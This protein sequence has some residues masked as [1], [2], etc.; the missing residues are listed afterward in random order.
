[1]LDFFRTHRGPILVLGLLLLPV[2][3][4]YGAARDD[5]S[6]DSLPRG[7]H[8]LT[9][10]VQESVSWSWHALSQGYGHYLWLVGIA[11]ENEELHQEV[12]QLKREI[13]YLQEDKLENQ[14]LMRLLNLVDYFPGA[15]FVP[16]RVIAAG[17]SAGYRS[18]RI[19][20]GTAHGVHRRA[21]VL[22]ANGVAGRVVVASTY[23][24]DVLLITDASSR[25]DVMTRRGRSRGVLRGGGKNCRIDAM[26]RTLDIDPGDLV[27]T[28]GLDGVFPKG[29]PVGEVSEVKL[30]ET[31]LYL[32]AWVKP[33][34]CEEN[35]EEL[36][37]LILPPAQAS[38][39]QIGKIAPSEPSPGKG[40][41]VSVVH[42]PPA[43]LPKTASTATPSLANKPSPANAEGRP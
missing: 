14:R 5:E 38:V 30:P 29:L 37:V 3:L 20:R 23:Y 12:S 2:I 6:S 10:P 19:N 36:L 31:G 40:A 27:V 15:R 35:I 4:L 33:F 9:G 17:Q 7:L 18:L 22:T 16:A 24:A 1:M 25:L 32:D 8:W 41:S 13:D 21:G 42:V 26:D 11:D 39:P 43:E 34:A 28:S